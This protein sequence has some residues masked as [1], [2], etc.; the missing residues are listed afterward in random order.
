MEEGIIIQD[1][2]SGTRLDSFL[3]KRFTQGSRAYWQKSVEA[4]YIKVND[5]VR[6]KKYVLSVGDMVKVEL[7]DQAITPRNISIVYE[8][9]DV[10]VFDKPLGVLTHSKGTFN[11]EFTIGEY[12]K[13]YYPNDSSG[14]PGIVHRLDRD[15]SGVMIAAKNERSRLFLQKQFADRKVKKA[16]IA[17]VEGV[18]RLPIAMLDWPIERNPR[19]PQ[20][21]RVGPNG[22]PAQTGYKLLCTSGDKSVLRLK[23]ETGRTHQLRV[24]LAHLGTPIIGDKLYNNNTDD[25]IRQRMMLHAVSISVL[26]PSHQLL[27]T[28][29]APTPSEFESFCHAQ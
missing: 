15:T 12:M 19:R 23:P 16:Y 13:R 29:K 2:E 7:P 3:A 6:N 18:P 25:G 26:L 17:G 28:F 10:I 20:T 1:S 21:F 9:E 4:G 5:E 24:H 27:K 22:K 14:R 8:D 11:P